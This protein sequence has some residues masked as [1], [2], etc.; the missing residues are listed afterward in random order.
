M[1]EILILS[2]KGGTGKT[3]LAAS[4]ACIVPENIM[5]DC[6]V[7]ASDLHLLLTPRIVE[8]HDFVSGVKAEVVSENCTACGTCIELCAF[9]AIALDDQ[10]HARVENF[11]CEGCGVCAWFCPE[12]AVI[13][14][15][16]HCGQWFRSETEYGPMVH[17]ALNPGEENSGRLVALVKRETRD[18]AQQLDKKW[19]VVDGPPGIGCPVIASMSGSDIIVAVTEPTES[20]LHDLKRVAELAAHFKVPLS[21]CVNKWD[22]N[23][24]KTGEITSW[25]ESNGIKVAGKIGFS[26]DVVKAIVAGKPIVKTDCMASKEIIHI[27]ENIKTQLTGK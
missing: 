20:G 10:G 8:R 18:L 22:L 5:A 27:W 11:S 9:N 25:C 12:E 21:V 1:K 7:D 19:V 3:T 16:N 4:F 15:D 14:H 17:A 13:L 23:E 24:K 26:E 2:G 6:D